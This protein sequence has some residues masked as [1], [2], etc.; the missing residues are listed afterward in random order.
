MQIADA[1][2]NS[3]GLMERGNALKVMAAKH[4]AAQLTAQERG[5]I[6]AKPPTGGVTH[7]SVLSSMR[8][9]QEMVDQILRYHNQRDNSNRKIER[10][11][12]ATAEL[13]KELR[14]Y[15]SEL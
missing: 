5:I 10:L 14:Q 11:S 15:R 8:N 2:E 12:A 1:E 6:S 13:L 9:D 4:G 7:A 3:P